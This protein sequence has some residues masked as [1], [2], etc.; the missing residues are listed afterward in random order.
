MNKTPYMEQYFGYQINKLEEIIKPVKSKA[1]SPALLS[2][3]ELTSNVIQNAN[4]LLYRSAFVAIIAVLEARDNYTSHHSERV[5]TMSERFSKCLNLLPHQV[6]LIEVTATVHDIGKVGIS[7]STLKKPGKLD[8]EQWVEMKS[9][10]IIGEEVINKAGKL[11]IIAK[12]VRSHHEKWNGTGYPDGLKGED[13]PFSSRIIAIC[14][15]ADAMMSTRVYRKALTPE[16]C[17]SELIKGKGVMYQPEL[18][19]AFLENWDTIVG[20]LYINEV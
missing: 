19:D 8:D 13:I 7:D 15:S 9:H 5:S 1:T 3:K 4:L 18:V 17:K 12:G 20:D 10:T 2:T 11:D 6:Q 14:D 16:I